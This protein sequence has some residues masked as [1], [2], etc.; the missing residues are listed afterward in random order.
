M[1]S[2]AG[3]GRPEPARFSV[4]WGRY[5][6]AS[7]EPMTAT[8]RAPPIWRVVSFMAEPTPALSRGSEPMI[9]SVAGAMAR[10]M[11]MAEEQHARAACAGSR[12]S[13]VTWRATDQA[14]GDDQQAAADHELGADPL[15]QAGRQRRRSTTISSGH[16]QHRGCRPRAA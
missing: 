5:T 14:G 11:P 15:D 7:T 16:R 9:D 13:R 6:E 3:A 4:T 2:T 8:P 10:P 1:A 12:G